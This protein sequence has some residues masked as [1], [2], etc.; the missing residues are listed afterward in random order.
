LREGKDKTIKTISSVAEMQA[1]ADR[2]RQSAKRIVLVPTMGFLHEGHLALIRSGRSLGDVLVVSIFV[3]PTQFGPGEDLEKYP[4]NMERDFAL[5]AQESVDIVFS[6]DAGDLYGQGFETFVA[7]QRLPMHLCGLS[8]PNHFRGVATVVAKLFNVV[9]PH[10]AVFGEKDFQQLQV[11]RRMVK[12]LNFSI[13]I[14]GHPTVREPDG[15]AMSS[16]NCY[17]SSPQRRSAVSLY[18][19]L[20]GAQQQV[21]KGIR[22]ASE[23]ISSAEE[24]IRSYA[25]TD[26]DYVAVC[27]P[28]TLEGVDTIHRPVLMALAVRVGKTRLIDN[29]IL[30]PR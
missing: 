19:A 12:D 3:N 13:A 10:V 15:L 9:Q 17:L 24:L 22:K 16:R 29:M 7:L 28:E 27:D 21:E 4:R 8:R 30:T 2:I 11:V 20:Q 6:P 14:I 1:R 18:L 23:L 25:D 26:I 5:A